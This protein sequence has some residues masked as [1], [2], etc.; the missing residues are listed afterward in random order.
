MRTCQT[1]A[2]KRRS[3]VSAYQADRDGQGAR[4]R[5]TGYFAMKKL[6]VW[7]NTDL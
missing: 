5:T 7:S 1:R 3:G 6:L 4:P 2:A